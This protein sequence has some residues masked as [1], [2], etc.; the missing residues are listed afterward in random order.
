MARGGYLRGAVSWLSIP[1]RE[2][3]RACPFAADA[4]SSRPSHCFRTFQVMRRLL[5]VLSACA[6]C[7]MNGCGQEEHRTPTQPLASF[8][9]E[10]SRTAASPASAAKPSSCAGNI[11]L[12]GVVQSRDRSYGIALVSLDGGSAMPLRKGQDVEPGATI[13]SISRDAVLLDCGDGKVLEVALQEAAAGPSG[14]SA[15]AV[16]RTATAAAPIIPARAA[17]RPELIEM[18]HR[19]LDA[20]LSD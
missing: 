10:Q 8:A 5:L 13:S 19:E 16:S 11:R 20:P 12:S 6:S 7:L 2:N 9:G 14:M 1:T 18:A 3:P 15:Q 4:D 17:A